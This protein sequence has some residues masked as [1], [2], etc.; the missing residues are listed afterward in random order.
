MK[1]VNEDASQAVFAR[2][3][4]QGVE[5]LLVGVNAAVETSPNRLQL[6]PP[7]ARTMAAQWRS[8]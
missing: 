8:F 1:S 3:A 6:P 4:Q 2:C 5:V 7:R